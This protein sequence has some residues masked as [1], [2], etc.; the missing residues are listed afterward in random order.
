V[1]QVKQLPRKSKDNSKV[2]NKKQSKV[3]SLE[4]FKVVIKPKKM[5][6]KVLESIPIKEIDEEQT[7]TNTTK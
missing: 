2:P 7:L 4:Y 1:A 3:N 5:E 6:T